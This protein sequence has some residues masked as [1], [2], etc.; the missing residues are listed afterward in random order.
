MKSAPSQPKQ[1]SGGSEQT[2]N[3]SEKQKDVRTSNI[4]AAKGFFLFSIFKNTDCFSS[5]L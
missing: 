1:A 5:R 2:F 4:A 3:K